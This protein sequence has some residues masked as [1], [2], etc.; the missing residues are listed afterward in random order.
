MVV[1]NTAMVTASGAGGVVEDT[2]TDSVV[3]VGVA[4]RPTSVHV[5]DLD[6]IAVEFVEAWD[7]TVAVTIVDDNEAP[8]PGATV[9]GVWEGM[10]T[11]A[12]VTSAAGVCGITIGGLTTDEV[13]FTVTD[14]DHPTLAYDPDA[15]TDPDGSSNGTTIVVERPD[16]LVPV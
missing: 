7:A 2:A 12:C 16:G 15:N 9:S 5:A 10:R 1:D 4:P 13:V 3:I 6:S 11:G 8:V 14:V